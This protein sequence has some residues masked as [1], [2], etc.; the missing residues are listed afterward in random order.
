MALWFG[1]AGGAGGEGQHSEIQPRGAVGVRVTG[2]PH[3]REEV[4][5][6]GLGGL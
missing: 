2:C 4:E 6:R 1:E 3:L 5:L